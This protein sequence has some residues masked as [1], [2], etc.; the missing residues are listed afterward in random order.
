MKVVLL[1]VWMVMLSIGAVNAATV[2]VTYDEP[3]LDGSG[4]ALNDLKETVIFWKQDNG[5]ETA[6][7]VPATA[8]T[9]G[10]KIVRTLTVA[11]PPPCGKTT[12]SVT[13]DAVDL[14]SQRSPKAGPVTSVKDI[15]STV[16]CTTPKEPTNLKLLFQ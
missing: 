1:V 7:T 5:I 15:S 6:I 2:Q 13:V 8:V 16:V 4:A 9:G 11:D 12:V 10:G 14:S 3:T